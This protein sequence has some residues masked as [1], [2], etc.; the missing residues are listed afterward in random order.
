MKRSAPDLPAEV[1]WVLAV[2]RIMRVSK[3]RAA[4]ALKGNDGDVEAA[5]EAITHGMYDGPD[6]SPG[7][8]TSVHAPTPAAPLG[9]RLRADVAA[10]SRSC[11]VSLQVNVQRTNLWQL[12]SLQQ[13][14]EDALRAMEFDVGA[15]EQYLLIHCYS[16]GYHCAPVEVLLHLDSHRGD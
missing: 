8:T 7:E 3:K 6:A 4:A 5:C 12:R 11:A 10:L 1:D 9:Q 14:A 2:S 13:E 16:V 15:A